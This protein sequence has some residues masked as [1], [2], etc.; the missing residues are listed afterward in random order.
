MGEGVEVEADDDGGVLGS[1]DDI[2]S[3]GYGFRRLAFRAG[4]GADAR[5]EAPREWADDDAAARSGSVLRTTRAR[6]MRA[7]GA[8]LE[9][10]GG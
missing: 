10:Q 2:S 4:V 3:C 1:E 7:E 9:A 6:S 8:Q 5:R